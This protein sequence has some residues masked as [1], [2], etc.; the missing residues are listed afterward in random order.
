M[1]PSNNESGTSFTSHWRTY[2]SSNASLDALGASLASAA[3]I[4][5]ACPSNEANNDV[6]NSE[7]PQARGTSC[8]ASMAAQ[9]NRSE[10]SAFIVVEACSVCK[11]ACNTPSGSFPS[12]PFLEAQSVKA[13][14]NSRGPASTRNKIALDAASMAEE[15]R[16][17]CVAAASKQ[18]DAA[19]RACTSP[20]SSKTFDRTGSSRRANFLDRDDAR[21]VDKHAAPKATIDA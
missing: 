10:A 11:K 16:A 5:G 12:S 7:P 21:A 14:P 20:S 6:A 17:P 3:T 18:A 15:V 1:P 8:G 2:S 9:P 19:W 4:R 13:T